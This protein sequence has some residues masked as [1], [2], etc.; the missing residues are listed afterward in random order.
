MAYTFIDDEKPDYSNEPWYKTA[1]R[2]VPRTIAR[3]AE[4]IAGFPGDIAATG[5]GLGNAA[6]SKITGQENVLPERLPIP[7]NP[8]MPYAGSFNLPTS[9][10]IKKHGT[11]A[12]TGEH[13]NPQSQNEENVDQIIGDAAT[14]LI[15]GLGQANL[16]WKGLKGLAK[17]A[18]KAIGRSAVGNISGWGAES[19]TGSPFV[20]GI[21]KMGAMAL[22]ALAGSRKG[23]VDLKDSSF[24]D[25]QKHIPKGTEINV[26]RENEQIKKL[27]REVAAG[28]PP[29]KKAILDRFTPFVR[30]V[31]KDIPGKTQ[32]LGIVNEHGKEFT[33]TIPGKPGGNVE[34]QKIINLVQDWNEW[35]QDP[36]L[37][38]TQR[39]FLK[40]GIG[41]ANSAID[42]YGA[43]NAKF[44]E[45]WKIGK[46]LHEAL[47]STNIV[48]RTLASSPLLQTAVSNPL[49]KHALY[50]G[51]IHGL[52]NSS[53]PV[54]GAVTAGSAAA[55]EATRFTQ[56]LWKSPVARK[57]YKD[58]LQ[59]ALKHNLPAAASSASKHSE[60]ADNLLKTAGRY[61]FVD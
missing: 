52:A 19:L 21:V 8:A 18:A 60:V 39:A 49:I 56:L 5:L 38:K 14:L 22:S 10:D 26:T 20:G 27:I 50:G 24:K 2:A 40:R 41:I 55:Y 59:H 15:P 35:Y 58:T 16:T 47:E 32:G 17:P 33:K 57:Y 23:V 30:N 36:S 34:L 54:L 12:L 3:G 9:G 7:L 11:E 51:A 13:L 29:N 53:Y 42:K 43:T 61:T 1:A 25:S 31:P 48:Q 45:P 6:I 4:A 44:Y 46:E 28:D 37:S